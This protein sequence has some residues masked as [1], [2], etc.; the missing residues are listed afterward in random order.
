MVG[1]R[2]EFVVFG[3]GWGLG[4][5]FTGGVFAGIQVSCRFAPGVGLV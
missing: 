3:S 2:A 1:C 4:G 5:W